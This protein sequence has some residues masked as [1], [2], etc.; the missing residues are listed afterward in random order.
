MYRYRLFT[1]DG[2]ASGTLIKTGIFNQPTPKSALT[3]FHLALERVGRSTTPVLIGSCQLNMR[4]AIWHDMRF[5]ET[6]HNKS[7]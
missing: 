7:P 4:H 2:D 5:S 6:G 3:A 1:R